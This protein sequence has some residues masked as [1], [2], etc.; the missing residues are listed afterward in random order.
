MHQA[1]CGRGKLSQSHTTFCKDL[2]SLGVDQVTLVVDHFTNA[3]LGDFDA[4]G[5][6]GAGVAVKDSVLADAISTS[7]EKSI[8]LGMQT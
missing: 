3:H 6:T 7:F 2:G 4:A 1:P 8:L 5:Q